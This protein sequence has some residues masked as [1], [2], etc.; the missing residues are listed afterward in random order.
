MTAPDGRRLL[1]LTVQ[2]VTAAEQLLAGLQVA[3]RER[4]ARAAATPDQ[5]MQR[6]QAALHG[7]AWAATY[8]QALRQLHGWATCLED[9]ARLGELE[10]LLLGAVF[11]EY[12]AQLAAGLPG[13]TRINGEAR[14]IR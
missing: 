11:S 10:R 9:G 2:A 7:Y 4:L 1:G 3:L 8:L 13:R 6:E 12:L 14:V 5:A